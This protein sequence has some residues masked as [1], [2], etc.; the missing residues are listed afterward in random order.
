MSDDGYEF[1][2]VLYD[3]DPEKNKAAIDRLRRLATHLNSPE[4][5]EDDEDE[6]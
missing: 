5:A 3:N 6:S 2:V 4:W 1:K